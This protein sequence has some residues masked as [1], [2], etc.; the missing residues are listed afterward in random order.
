[1]TSIG[2][3][4]PGEMGAGVAGALVRGGHE[5]YWISAGRSADSARRAAEEGLLDAGELPALLERVELVV[6]IVPP[7]AAVDVAKQV[8]GFTG[9]YLDANAISPGHAAEVAAIIEAGGGTAVD[10]GIIGGPPRTGTTR[11]YLSGPGA[12]EVAALFPPEEA[13]IRIVTGDRFGASAVKMGYAAW[14]KGSAALMLGI[15]AMA[16]ATGVEADLVAEW[17]ETQPRLLDT[18][19]RA[20]ASAEDRGWRWAGEM[21]EIAETFRTAGLPGGFHEAAAELY[22]RSPRRTGAPAT[23]EVLDEVVEALLGRGAPAR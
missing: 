20:G 17:S 22:R 5:V 23:D 8:A 16:R 2:I 11:L 15:R 18:G 9:R 21:E 14:T 6:S 1:M 7:H 10:A 19:R 3:L 4:H 12:E 13:T